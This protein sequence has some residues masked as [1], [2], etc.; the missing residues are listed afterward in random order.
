[1]SNVATSALS[2]RE[3]HHFLLRKLHSL[4]GIVPVGVFLIEH[5]LTNS[6]AFGWF[7]WFKSGPKSFNEQVHWLHSLPFLPMLEL[8][9]IFLP[10]AFHAGYGVLIALSAEPNSG[11]Y[12]YGANRRYTL[13]RLTAWITLV[14]IVV[15]LL[16]FRFAHWVGWGPEFLDPANADKFEITRRGLQQWTPFGWAVPPAVTFGF[17]ALGL[18]AAVFHFC[19]GIWTFCISW[20]VTIGERAQ[21]RV[22]YACTA[23][24]VVLLSWGLS[25]LYAFRTAP[26]DAAHASQDRG[27]NVAAAHAPEP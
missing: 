16:K 13:Q 2:F 6:S 4:T 5:L 17:Y 9:G 27:E 25:S 11:V 15:H 23:V 10:L 26:P 7:G 24:G 3:R 22:G 8:F 1:M 12:G 21:R 19:N 14:F 18:W 20:G